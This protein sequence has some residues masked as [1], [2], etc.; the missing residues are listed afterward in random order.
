M[1]K[2]VSLSSST[3]FAEIVFVF[4][5][6]RYGFSIDHKIGLFRIISFEKFA[7]ESLKEISFLIFDAT[8]LP[9]AFMISV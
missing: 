5:L 2:V 7:I 6:Y 8:T 9:D 3:L 4:I 1:P